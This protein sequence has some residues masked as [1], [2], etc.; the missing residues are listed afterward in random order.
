[1]RDSYLVI[2]IMLLMCCLT[3]AAQDGEILTPGDFHQQEWQRLVAR[4]Q[5][6]DEVQ[7]TRNQ[8][9]MDVIHY[10][11]DLDIT[12]TAWQIIHGAVTMTAMALVDNYT[13]TDLNF[14]KPITVDSV[15]MTGQTSSWT[16]T[17]D[18]I[19]ITWATPLDSG[20]TFTTEVYYHGVPPSSGFGSFIFSMHNGHS[21]VWSLSEPIG[22]RDWWACKD[23]PNDKADSTDVL[24]TADTSNI[25]TSNGLLRE[26]IDNGNGTKTYHWHESY[27]ISTY[28][29]SI[30]STNYQTIT[31]E[32]V[33][34]AGDTMPIPHYVYPE[35]YD[36][37][38]IDFDITPS[39]I[40]ILR[41]YFG[42]YPF[43]AESYGMAEFNWGG[44]MEHQT[45]TTYGSPLIQ[46]NHAYDW[47]L[48]H[49]LGHQW[50][51]DLVTL[52]DWPHIWLNEGF[53]S[54]SE[55]LYKE[56]IQGMSSYHSYMRNN[57]YVSD[58]SGPIYD[59]DPLFGSYTVYHI[60]AW[61]LHMLPAGVGDSMWSIFLNY[62]EAYAYDTA[63]IQDFQ[64][65]AESVWGA[66][67][68]WF[69]QEW[70]WGVNR[71]DYQWAW[72]GGFWEGAY[73]LYITIT[74]QQTNADLFTM[75]IQM[76]ITGSRTDTT[77]ILWDS[78]ETQTFEIE[79]PWEPSCVEF[80]P[81]QWILRFK[82]E[83]TY[84]LTIVTD[85]LL[86]GYIEIPYTDTLRAIGGVEPYTWEIIAGILPAGLMLDSLSGAISG[87]PSSDTLTALTIKVSDDA[88]GSITQ[89]LV[90]Q[91][92]GVPE[93]VDDLVI[94]STGSDI[95]LRWNP[96]AIANTY[97]IYRGNSIGLP[98]DS[99]TTVTDTIFIDPVILESWNGGFYHV[100]SRREP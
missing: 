13:E 81:D 4:Y 53:A 89:Y 84:P 55:A 64:A 54:Y 49:E 28:L 75:P 67:L 76:E 23:V 5:G 35:D 17:N 39:A 88:S 94:E 33:T 32:Y 44:A 48:V 59:P 65:I 42:E 73:H 16:H 74:Q 66:D 24:I 41:G 30:T 91:I 83:V 93:A 14:S 15:I 80:D 87:I 36:A 37:A 58:P 19:T 20:D 21:V 77:I 45:L 31:D 51:G 47:I 98:L 68:S 70:I 6:L 82:E 86:P 12:D 99:L 40:E 63:T 72:D 56:A 57:L 52:D 78:L 1:M 97:T 8:A 79:L 92:F 27:P 43:T 7:P 10:R 95:I 61:G 85:T 62:R 29:V 46:G 90:I 100:T 60:G 69:F 18:L 38:V 22:A 71:P 3:A 50:W 2:G 25:S 9:N 11:L 96:V 34:M 26:V